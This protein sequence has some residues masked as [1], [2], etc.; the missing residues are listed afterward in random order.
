MSEEIIVRIQ[1]GVKKSTSFSMTVPWDSTIEELRTQ[2]REEQKIDPSFGVVLISNGENLKNPDITLYDLG[3]C[4]DSLIIC[5]I[6]KATGKDIEALIGSK[7]DDFKVLEEVVLEVDF[8][9]RPFGFAVWANEK[10]ENAIVTKV[11]SGSALAKG[12][13]IGY[14]VYKVDNSLVFNKDHTEVLTCLKSVSCPI[15]IQFVDCGQENTVEFRDK[16]LGFTV[17][18]EKE[19]ETNAKVSKVTKHAANLGVKI[20]SQVVAVDGQYVFG[21]KHKDIIDII[22]ISQFPIKLTFRRPPKLLMLSSDRIQSS[23]KKRKNKKKKKFAW[24]PK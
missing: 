1:V 18:Q 7:E 16:P 14:C 19:N 20:G 10:G 5:V 13:K 3:I 15:R 22:N 12:I 4:N 2:L 11:S 17:V 24:S 9:N 23:S 6:S 21:R 8:N